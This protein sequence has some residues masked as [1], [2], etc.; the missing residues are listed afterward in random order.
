VNG[1]LTPPEELLNSSSVG[2]RRR[3]TFFAHNDP[4]KQF[5]NSSGWFGARPATLADPVNA[6]IQR[7][8]SVL[9]RRALFQV[10][11]CVGVA[12]GLYIFIVGVTG[13][14]LVFRID[15][16]RASYP[17]L[18]TASAAGPAADPVTILE[19]VR[20][21]YPTGRVSGIAA[22]TSARPTYLAYVATGNDFAT[23]LVDPVTARVLGELPARS[24]VRTLQDLHFDLLAGRT[25]RVVN[26]I[27]AAL[28]LVM[29][30]TGL[31]IWWQ[32]ARTWQRGLTVDFSRNWKRI[33]WDFHSA[34]GVWTL[35]L[36]AM[37]AATGIY[38]AFPS[39]FRAAVNRI[40]PVSVSRAPQSVRP[41]AGAA[42]APWRDQ[43]ARA[44]GHAPGQFVARV[45]LPSSERAAFLV[46]FSPTVPTPLGTPLTSI[47]L[48][49]VSGTRLQE[50]ARGARTAGD[51]VIDWVAPLHVGNFGG[52]AVRVVWLVLGLSPPLLFV[53]GFLM[54]W[55]RVVWPQ[56]ARVAAIT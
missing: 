25:G 4:D 37:W 20:D 48:D 29:C 26:G 47:Y 50:P 41:S 53:T 44:R 54:W 39:Q 9:L 12:S 52:N 5:R 56:R 33:N 34:V 31:V 49:R 1:R 51:L 19:H 8:Q 22:P 6:F 38:F 43:L 28:L 17:Q 10:H 11:L 15:L 21:A 30:L 40:S 32:G 27:G 42:D 7:P 18:F 24:F 13:A 35:L 14:A 23:V 36:V 46:M 45:V 16:Q 55:T 2:V 3:V